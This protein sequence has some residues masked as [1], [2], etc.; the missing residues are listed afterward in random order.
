MTKVRNNKM[1]RGIPKAKEAKVEKKIEKKIEK[2]R[3]APKV[4]AI[5]VGLVAMCGL[6]EVES[7]RGDEWII[8][9]TVKNVKANGRVPMSEDALRVFFGV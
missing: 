1:P 2:K 8:I 6:W 4:V 5:E 7:K 3:E 9:P